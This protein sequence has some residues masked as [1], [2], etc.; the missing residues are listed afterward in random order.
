MIYFDG[1]YIAKYYLAEPDSPA[2]IAAA[3]KEGSVACSAQGKVEVAAVFHRKL[4]E[5]AFTQVDYQVLRRQFELDC[6]TG[7][8]SWLPVGGYPIENAVRHFGTLPS[9]VF[10]RTGDAIHLCTALEHGFHDIYTSDKHVLAAAPF[11]GLNG[12]TLSNHS[13]NLPD[14]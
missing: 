9:T 11:F 14:S 13:T 5:G 6:S 7:L 3:G 8:W 2:V 12:I 10:L 1:C 4:R